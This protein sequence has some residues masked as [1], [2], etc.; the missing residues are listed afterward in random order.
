MRLLAGSPF[1]GIADPRGLARTVASAF[2]GI[3]LYET[4]DPD[5]AALALDTLDQLAVL[6]E[7]VEEL[8][9]IARRA[10]RAKLRK[11]NR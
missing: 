3:E 6:I 1:E 7:V 4:V 5:G 2:I 11:I 8:G 9:P 10:V